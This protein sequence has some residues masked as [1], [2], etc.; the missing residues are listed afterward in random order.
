MQCSCLQVR[1]PVQLLCA[2]QSVAEMNPFVKVNRAKYN[3]RQIGVISLNFM[4]QLS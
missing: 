2:H 3:E 4:V 1:N